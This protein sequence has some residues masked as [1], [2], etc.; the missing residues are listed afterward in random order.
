MEQALKDK[1]V[2]DF[3]PP[4]GVM[5]GLV[6]P[7]TGGP[8]DETTEHPLL[9]CFR[10]GMVGQSDLTELARTRRP[11]GRGTRPTDLPG[12]DYRSR[13]VMRP[14]RSG[15]GR[16]VVQGALPEETP[17]DAEDPSATNP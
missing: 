1:P 4:P 8:A 16:V 11:R 12:S 13:S 10:E 17:P 15:W 7:A 9:V 14:R 6:D 3:M 2:R 5:F